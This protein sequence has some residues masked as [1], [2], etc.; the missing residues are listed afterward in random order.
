MHLG[1]LR[2]LRPA[3]T[4]LIQGYL[5]AQAAALTER[6]LVVPGLL[7]GVERAEMLLLVAAAQEQMGRR[8]RQEECA[9]EA[10]R[11]AEASDDEALR[12]RAA[13]ALAWCLFQNSRLE[14]AEASYRRVLACARGVG[15]RV[16]EALAICKNIFA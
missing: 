8:E 9:R 4:H 3:Q 2:Y 7:T 6:A 12:G 1:A 13:T 11:L 15:D 5:H 10:V 14:E 16:S